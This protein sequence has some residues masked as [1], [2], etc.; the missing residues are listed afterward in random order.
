MISI[1]YSYEL[2]AERFVWGIIGL[3]IAFGLAIITIALIKDPTISHTVRVG[4]AILGFSIF[5][6]SAPAA[7]SQPKV[8]YYEI[9]ITDTM[10]FKEFDTRYEVIKQRGEIYTVILKETNNEN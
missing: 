1:L 4:F 6:I 10:N 9:T 8:T 3:I 2:F 5:L 7:L